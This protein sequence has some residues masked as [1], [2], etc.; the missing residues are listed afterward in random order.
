[1]SK[2]VLIVD[3][4][5]EILELIKSILTKEGY[6]TFTASD[7]KIGREMFENIKPDLLITDIVLPGKEGLD[8]IL[9]LGRIYPDFKVIAISGGDRIE[10]SYYLELAQVLGAQATLE[11]PFVPHELISLVHEILSN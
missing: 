10:S 7:G 5:F 4:D 2:K 8:I 6:S 9:E 3:D 1:M 11:K